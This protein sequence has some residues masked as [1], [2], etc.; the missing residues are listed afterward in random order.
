MAQNRPSH[1][2]DSIKGRHAM[3]GFVP[4]LIPLAG[5]HTEQYI[6]TDA[7]DDSCRLLNELRLWRIFKHAI[8]I[9]HP[10]NVLFW[11]TKQALGHFFLGLSDPS[12][13]LGCHRGVVRALV[14]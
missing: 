14:V 11:R 12:Q 8:V 7:P 4:S 3:V 6:G 1:G 13:L 5:I 2:V 9:S 10:Y